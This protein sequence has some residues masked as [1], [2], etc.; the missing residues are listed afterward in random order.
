VHVAVDDATHLAYVEVLPNK[1]QD[2]TGWF[3]GAGGGVV[4]RTG[5]DLP[6]DSLG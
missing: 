5:D 3:S 2:K 4:Q 1:Q 6:A